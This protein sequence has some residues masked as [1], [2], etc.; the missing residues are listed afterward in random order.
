MFFVMRRIGNRVIFGIIFSQH[1]WLGLGVDKDK[2]ALHVLNNL[3]S[4][5]NSKNSIPSFKKI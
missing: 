3:K 5:W 1:F 4:S 2:A